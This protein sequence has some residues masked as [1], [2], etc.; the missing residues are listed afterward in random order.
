MTFRDPIHCR[1]LLARLMAEENAQLATLESL[2]VRE[3]ALL[4]ARDMEGLDET[5][6]ARQQC[7]GHI[8]RIEDERLA[9]VR[10]TGRAGDAA[11]LPGLLTWCDPAGILRSVVQE[12][13]DRTRRCREQNDRNGRLVGARLQRVDETRA[14]GP[15]SGDTRG[16]GRLLTER[17]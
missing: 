16:N 6:A 3:H 4:E 7:V 2:L 8:L 13:R 12:Y 9:L 15:G 1:E 17:A 5:A 14:Y 11:G 10:A